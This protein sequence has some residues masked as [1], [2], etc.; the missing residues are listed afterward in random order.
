MER[1]AGRTALITLRVNGT[2]SGVDHSA[3][4]MLPVVRAGGDHALLVAAQLA[5]KDRPYVRVEFPLTPGAIEPADLSGYSGVSFEVR[6]EAAGRLLVHAYH[7]RSTDAYA[8][9]FVAG[10]EWH[11]VQ[12]PFAS[13]RRR[14]ANGGSLD[15]KDVRAL[16]FELG[17]T[18][19]S[20]VWL[21]LDNVRFY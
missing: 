18:A 21:E 9:P 10:A 5:D 3:M 6:G 4:L 13:L 15:L 7:V 16:L 8:A 17:G 14:A 1:G 20:S 19:G 12:V 2:D 11:T